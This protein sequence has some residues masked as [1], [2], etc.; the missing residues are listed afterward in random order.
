MSSIL[1]NFLSKEKTEKVEKWF[2]K[3]SK[4]NY[5]Q[6]FNFNLTKNQY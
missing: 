5:F 2:Y 4:K 3:N 6:L 1:N